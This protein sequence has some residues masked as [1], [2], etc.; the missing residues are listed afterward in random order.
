ME[1]V[2]AVVAVVVHS[3][4]G[5]TARVAEAV[6]RGAAA[7]D[8]VTVQ[9][10]ALT[11]EQ[12]TEGRWQDDAIMAALAQ[13]DA[14]VFGAPTYMGMV[15]GIFKCF[16][17]ATAGVWFQQ[18]WKDKLAGGFTSSGYASGDKV[19][20][21]HY[22]ATLAAQLRM[23]WVGPDAPPSNLTGDG[24]DIDQWGYYL[25]VGAVGSVRPDAG[26]PDAGDLK[27]AE[28]Y[29]RR[30]AHIAAR[31]ERTAAPAVTSA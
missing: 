30:I 23:V 29:G 22:M 31:W 11:G 8:G 20:T 26:L 12:V 14:I 24:Q 4:M 1:V 28:L 10:L 9:V 5:N 2:M 19:M 25:G 3:G 7:V 6:A 17:D 15:S 16:A 18:A 21:L 27:T 13:A